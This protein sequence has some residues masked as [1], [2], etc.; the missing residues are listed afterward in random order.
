MEELTKLNFNHFIKK[1]YPKLP[2]VNCKNAL[3]FIDK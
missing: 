3:E 1:Y 2:V